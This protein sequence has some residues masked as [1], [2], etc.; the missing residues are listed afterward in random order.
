MQYKKASEKK[1]SEKNGKTNIRINRENGTKEKNRQQKKSGLG[2]K[3]HDR[4][5]LGRFLKNNFTG[6]SLMKNFRLNTY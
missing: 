5:I 1:K 4:K 6:R 3:C 2:M